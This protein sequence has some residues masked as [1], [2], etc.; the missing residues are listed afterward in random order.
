MFATFTERIYIQF[1]Y[2]AYKF[3]LMNTSIGV[4]YKSY[5]TLDLNSYIERHIKWITYF[6]Y[7]TSKFLVYYSTEILRHAFVI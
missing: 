3:I 4:I 2:E 1:S 6:L 5:F 7:N